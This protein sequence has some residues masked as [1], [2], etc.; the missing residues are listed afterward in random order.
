[1]PT[2]FKI[3]VADEVIEDLHQRLDMA[4]WPDEIG[5][6]WQYGTDLNYLKQLCHY[7]RN[8]FD[9][10]EQE[11]VLNQFDH[12]TT[13][14]DDRK[15]HFIHQR[16]KH[17]AALPLLITHGW[18]GSI[19]EFVKIIEPLTDPTNHG[20][21][22]ADAFHV[23][24]PSIPGY[25]FSDAPTAPGFDQKSVAEGNIQLMQQLGYER[26]GVQ[27][28]DWGSAIS[29]WNAVLAP[30][31]VVGLHLNLV[32]AG[33]PKHKKNPME[34]VTEAEQQRLEDRQSSM[35][36]GRGYQQIQG[37]K[38]QTLGYGLHDSPIGLA[39]WITEKFHAWT[40]C[41]GDIERSLSKDELLTNIMIYWVTG[42]ITSSTRLYYESAH[43]SNDMA[44][45]GRIETP[46]GCAIFPAE[47]YIP[48]RIWAEEIYN[49][50]HW[51]V[52]D[53]GGHFAALEEP[54][55]FVED[56]RQFF[57]KLT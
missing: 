24:C 26:Y 41:H 18:P 8:E 35:K 5:E 7:W 28:G 50:Q 51:S 31:Q 21:T 53:R 3:S 45:A 52:M 47:L 46:T 2:P 36:E 22:S 4:R 39:A 33:F 23:I 29:S 9:W 16:S 49:I 48:P 56:I 38:P 11:R 14:I 34:G 13:D 55:L 27:G 1:M 17:E 20:G 40:D 43:S 12:F 25:G 44:E 37:S 19:T 32:F 42:T 30:E 10:R 6:N 54:G 57:S 15:L